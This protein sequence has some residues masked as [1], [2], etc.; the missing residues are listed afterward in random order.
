[1][2]VW[3]LNYKMACESRPFLFYVAFGHD[4]LPSVAGRWEG[5]L[6]SSLQVSATAA[7]FFRQGTLWGMVCRE[8]PALAEALEACSQAVIV[9]GEV[10]HHD[11]LDYL[12]ETIAYLT[13]LTEQGARGVHDPFTLNWHS[14]EA[15]QDLAERGSIFNPF[16]HV[17]LLS[18]RDPDG[19]TW[20]HTRGMLKFGRPD[21]SVRG[22][23]EA[24]VDSVARMLDRFIAYQALG[25]VI[26]T[27]REVVMAGLEAVYRPGPV[28]GGIEDPDFN[29]A[30]VEIRKDAASG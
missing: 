23:S 15:W 7:E 10:D 26:E 25:G 4:G 12:R 14:A 1:L 3:K 5:S 19:T 30:H 13:F 18:S 8:Q 2:A 28:E 11:S 21:L 17:A 6:R 27:G 9:K 22:V 29:N 16:D 20:L 24:E